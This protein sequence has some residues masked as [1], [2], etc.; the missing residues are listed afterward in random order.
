[1]S[2]EMETLSGNIQTDR[3]ERTRIFLEWQSKDSS[4][5]GSINEKKAKYEKLD[6]CMKAQSLC[7][8]GKKEAMLSLV[9]SAFAESIT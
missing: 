4:L 3:A 1:M 8:S 2:E 6:L 7:E 5:S 9:P